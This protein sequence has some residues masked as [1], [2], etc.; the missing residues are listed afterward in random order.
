MRHNIVSR[1]A[2]CVLALAVCGSAAECAAASRN[3]TTNPAIIQVDT[4]QDVFAIGDAHGDP[5][6]LAGV[7]VG[8]KLIGSVPPAWDQVQWTGGKAVVV[9]TGDM[10]DKGSNSLGVIALVRALQSAAAAGGGQVIIT[11]GNHEGEFLADPGGKKTSEFSTE[12]KAAGLDPQAVGNCSGD[13]GAFLCGLP[14]AVRVNDWF[15]SHAGNT[16]NRTMEKISKDIED[17]FAKDSFATKQLVGD[18]SI[19]EARLNKKGPGGLPWFD[20]GSDKADPQKLLEKYVKTLGVKHLVQGH[21]YENVK[22]PDKEDR[23]EFHFFQR[24]GLLFLIDTGMSEGIEDS[25]SIGG[26]LHI[27]G[28][29]D[30]Q[31]AIVICPNG[32][33]KTLW[34][35]KKTDREEHLCGE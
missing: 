35:K 2:G 27:A 13:I 28:T 22:F 17:G 7:L 34:D 3:W 8:A 21:Q 9:I 18:N 12:L 19:L 1:A 25:D 31:K 6:R 20:D 26:A 4:T 11:M 24:Y 14:I 33:E 29:G 32:A 16:D 15:F 5:Q 30:D 23:K 10:I